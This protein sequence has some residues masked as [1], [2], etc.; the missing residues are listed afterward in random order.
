MSALTNRNHVL[1]ILTNTVTGEQYVG[2]TVAQKRAYLKSA[3]E[4]FRKHCVRAQYE[5]LDWRLCTALRTHS[6]AAFTV[7]VHSVVRGRVAAHAAER[8]LI[9]QLAPALNT[10]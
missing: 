7:S 5:Q 9:A 3:R 4:R 6:P 8:A 1:Y 10:R 2:L